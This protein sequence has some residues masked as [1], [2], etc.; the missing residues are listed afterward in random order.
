MEPGPEQPDW[1]GVS[2]ES[3][4]RVGRH[5]RGHPQSLGSKQQCLGICGLAVSPRP[6]AQGVPCFPGG[7][8][9]PA[10]GLGTPSPKIP[11]VS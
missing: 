9:R 1:G 7:L 3:S 6:G 11:S 5:G 10:S 2:A 4:Y 8:V